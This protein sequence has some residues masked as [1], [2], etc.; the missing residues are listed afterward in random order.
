[1]N[2]VTGS[3]T[4]SRPC[5][6]SFMMAAGVNCLV[7]EPMEKTVCGVS[8]TENSSFAVLSHSR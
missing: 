5:S 6:C 2:R 1:M 3:V 8:K 7:F 4:F